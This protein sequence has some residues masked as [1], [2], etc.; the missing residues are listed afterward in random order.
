MHQSKYLQHNKIRV[1]KGFLPPQEAISSA[2]SEDIPCKPDSSKS[3]YERRLSLFLEPEGLYSDS[4]LTQASVSAI[5]NPTYIDLLDTTKS[6]DPNSQ[7]DTTLIDHANANV[8][9]H[10][11]KFWK[12]NLSCK[13][14]PSL[15]RIS[16][17]LS[18]SFKPPTIEVIPYKATE[19]H[20]I[21]TSDGLE[22]FEREEILSPLLIYKCSASP[23]PACKQFVSDQINICKAIHPPILN[24]ELCITNHRS[25][26]SCPVVL[27]QVIQQALQFIA[28]S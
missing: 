28:D 26:D 12:G 21:K 1:K 6:L 7:Q 8:I 13:K 11:D 14:G 4:A 25:N 27:L 18:D 17:T 16:A 10:M 15:K 24:E 19:E 20:S 23:R 9:P 3:F 2:V 5:T 22:N